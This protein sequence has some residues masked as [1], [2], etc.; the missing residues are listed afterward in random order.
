MKTNAMRHEIISNWNTN[1]FITTILVFIVMY[2]VPREMIVNA[3]C[4]NMGSYRIFSILLLLCLFE[5]N[6][7]G[8]DLEETAKAFSEKFSHSGIFY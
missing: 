4:L 7:L 2:D 8:E 3:E 1:K 6:V 5:S